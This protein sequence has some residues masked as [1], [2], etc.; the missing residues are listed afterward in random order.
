[1]NYY[2]TEQILL[3]AVEI[4]QKARSGDY[5][6]QWFQREFGDLH[7]ALTTVVGEIEIL[8]ASLEEADDENE[9]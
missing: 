7:Y 2:S 1:M 5:S 3:G 8:L 4:M 6:E 9:T